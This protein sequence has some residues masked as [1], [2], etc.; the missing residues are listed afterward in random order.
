M[1]DTTVTAVMANLAIF[2]VALG[3]FKGYD[4]TLK[5]ELRELIIPFVIFVVWMVESCLV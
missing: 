1:T 2:P 5:Q 3:K 4:N